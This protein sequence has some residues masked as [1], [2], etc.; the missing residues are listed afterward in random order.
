MSA[1]KVITYFRADPWDFINVVSF[2]HFRWFGY[3]QVPF[4]T[5]INYTQGNCGQKHTPFPV[6]TGIFEKNT[7]DNVTDLP[8]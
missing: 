6:N 5:L 8:F 3:F 7:L 4:S 1:N 2:E